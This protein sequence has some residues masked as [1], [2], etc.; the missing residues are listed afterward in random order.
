MDLYS[1]PLDA[2]SEQELAAV[3]KKVPLNI[4]EAETKNRPAR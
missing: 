2:L 3:M 4:Y 1:K